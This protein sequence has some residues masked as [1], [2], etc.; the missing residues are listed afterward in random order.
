MATIHHAADGS[1]LRLLQTEREEADYPTPPPGTAGTVTFDESSNA[2]VVAALNADWNSH[3][4]AGG[5]LQRSG[6]DVT[7]A[8]DSPERAAR[9]TAKNQAATLLTALRGGS[10]S[11]AQIQRALAYLLA[12]ELKRDQ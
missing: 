9:R 4:V 3:R 1:L 12:Q 6:A 2:G 5:K 8:A 7:I 10:A 11:N